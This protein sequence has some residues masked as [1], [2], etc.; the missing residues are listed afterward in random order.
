MFSTTDGRIF[1]QDP[2]VAGKIEVAGINVRESFTITKK[3]DGVKGSTM[4]W[5]IARIAGEQPNGTFAVPALGSTQGLSAPSESGAA[6]AQN[7]SFTGARGR[8]GGPTPKPPASATSA[9]PNDG[10]TLLVR[11]ADA[12]VD[13]YALVLERAL[14]TYQGRIKPDE[15]RSLL[16]SAYIQRRQLSSVA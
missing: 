2:F 10:R 11:E 7:L 8:Q 5:E 4:T 6:T 9:A 14:T 1:F 3:W 15:V 13:A 16:L 12:L